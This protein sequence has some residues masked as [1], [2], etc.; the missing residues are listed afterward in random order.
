[1]GLAVFSAALY[2]VMVLLGQTVGLSLSLAGIAGM[3]ISVGVTADS[4]IVGFE[5]LK[6][7]IR[8]GKSLRAA[9]DRGMK[10]ALK[11]IVVADFVTGSA[12]VILFFLAVGPVQGFALTLGIGTIID[13]LVAYFFTRPAVNLLA[14]SRTFSSG[15]F[16]GMREALGARS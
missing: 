12:A 10:R 14:R 1:G 5:R 16:I 15:R 3:I 6:D 9:V 13:L 8:A 2:T 4:Y 7:E 11:T